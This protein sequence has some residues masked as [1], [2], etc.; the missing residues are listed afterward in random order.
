MNDDSIL[1]A[2]AERNPVTEPP[3]YDES[4][5][6]GL[7]DLLTTFGTDSTRPEQRARPTRLR[8]TLLACGAVAVCGCVAVVVANQGT[9]ETPAPAAAKQ[10]TH[11]A[12]PVPVPPPTTAPST[13]Q[14]PVAD[15]ATPADLVVDRSTL[16]ISSASDYLLQAN[17]ATHAGGKTYRSVS[18]FDEDNRQNFHDQEFGPKGD[19][20]VDSFNYEGVGNVSASVVLDYRFHQYTANPTPVPAVEVEGNSTGNDAAG[21]I[22]DLKSGH[23][24]VTGTTTINGRAVLRLSNDEPGMNRQIWVDVNTYLPV[25]MTAHGSWGSYQMDYTWIPRTAESVAAAF[26]PQIPNGFTKVSQLSGD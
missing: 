21:I 19:L 3:S 26:A 23:D 15:G 9:S 16:A 1:Q 22:N 10:V 14:F 17:E 12:P 2:L 25:R 13:Q 7:R 18:W 6:S 24:K 11:I 5:E 8:M 20:Q 4:A